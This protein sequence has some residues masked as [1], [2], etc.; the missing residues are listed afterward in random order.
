MAKYDREFLVQY[1]QD[2]Y[3]LYL[4]ENRIQRKQHQSEYPIERSH[5]DRTE[6]LQKP[7][8][9]THEEP[10]CATWFA[11]IFAG[12]ACFLLF[13]E[14]A[15]LKTHIAS[16]MLV[17]LFGGI[18]STTV[19]AIIGFQANRERNKANEDNYQL[20]LHDYE[21]ALAEHQKIQAL[22]KQAYNVNV[23][24]GPYRDMYAIAYLYDYFSCSQ[25]TDL[26]MALNTYV[27]EQI[28]DRLD[29]LIRNQEETILT[30]YGIMDNQA[31]MMRKMEKIHQDLSRRLRGIHATADEQNTYLSMI[32]ANSA[33]TSYFSATQYFKKS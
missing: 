15:F 20:K 11:A 30:L 31:E 28:K 32:E 22:L 17:L 12:F 8:K 24:P 7:R 13:L 33:V 14:I 27:L 6:Q 23:I 26:S 16:F 9:P 19:F 1:L 2:I 18:V 21:Y 25:E 10:G 3:A 5:S 29:N 4:A